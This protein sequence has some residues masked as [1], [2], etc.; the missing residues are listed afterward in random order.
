MEK[1]KVGFIPCGVH[2]NVKD[3][4]GRPFIDYHTLKM[5]ADSLRK[6]GLEV[7]EYRNLVRTIVRTIA[8]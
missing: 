7:Y 4:F 3:S 1:P 8:L 5:A 6:W 2:V